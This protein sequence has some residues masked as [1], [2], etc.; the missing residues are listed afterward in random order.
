MTKLET[1]DNLLR[2]DC[3][4]HPSEG[5]LR[6]IREALE[7]YRKQI[8]A[9]AK[10]YNCDTC[11]NKGK[12]VCHKC[13]ATAYRGER[14][15]IP[16]QYTK[17]SQEVEFHHYTGNVNGYHYIGTTDGHFNQ[18]PVVK[19]EFDWHPL[20]GFPE[21]EG[22]PEEDGNYLCTLRYGEF[23]SIGVLEF[24]KDLYKRDN[25][26]FAEHKGKKKQGFI[27]YD[28]EYGYYEMDNVAAWAYL[29]K[30]FDGRIEDEE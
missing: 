3:R 21:V 28:S 16:T 5:E 7:H 22:Y 29:P 25:F 4:I 27:D 18:L 23:D 14:V 12:D 19:K 6:V 11:A 26:D 17:K 20:S 10:A 9:E 30:P 24:C 13:V 15:S 8:V 2:V 1:I